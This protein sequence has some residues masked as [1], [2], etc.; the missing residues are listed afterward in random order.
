M[1]SFHTG[2]SGHALILSL[3]S[4][5]NLPS[6]R[7]SGAVLCCRQWLGPGI[8][9]AQEQLP[10]NSAGPYADDDTIS[11]ISIASGDRSGQR[12]RNSA[13]SLPQRAARGAAL[14]AVFVDHQL[15]PEKRGPRGRR[16]E[17]VVIPLSSDIDC[18]R[19]RTCMAYV[20]VHPECLAT[21]GNKAREHA[22]T[23][24]RYTRMLEDHAE[25]YRRVFSARRALHLP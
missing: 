7:G 22:L 15:I 23:T 5:L 16:F 25:V 11:L 21:L 20:I 13:D 1:L 19:D 6:P 4:R 14:H 3:D 2:A 10:D 17:V 9:G 12:P 18:R 24:F 8:T